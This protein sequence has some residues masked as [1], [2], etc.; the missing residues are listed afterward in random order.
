MDL[1]DIRQITM[2]RDSTALTGLSGGATTVSTTS[3]PS[4]YYKGKIIASTNQSS[5]ATPTTDIA[6]GKAFLPHSATT[7]AA[8][9]G[10][11]YVFGW[12]ASAP[13]VFSVAQGPLVKTAD[14]VNGA[15]AYAFPSIPDTFVPVAYVTIDFYGA[16][17]WV[18][19]TG[20]W[21]AS[22]TAIGTVINCALLPAQPL[23]AVS[24]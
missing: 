3:T 16:T 13:T 17:P 24:A 18:F 2:N 5:G 1:F 22:T 14:V 21:N 11:V 6:T 7:L 8:S 15:A 9:T 19:G 20:N 4:Y 10:C 12:D 23:T